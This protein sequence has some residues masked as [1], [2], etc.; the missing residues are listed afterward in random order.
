MVPQL[1]GRDHLATA[2]A[3]IELARTVAFAA[4][5]ALGGTLVGW[6]GAGTA[7]GLAAGLSALAA[8]LLGGL[9]DPSRPATAD[10]S[11]WRDA[12]EGLAFVARHS[13]LGPVFVTQFVFNTSYFI[14]LA[15]FVPYAARHLGLSAT[16]IGLTLGCSGAGMI[17]GALLAP[18]L[19]RRLPFGLLVG[20]GP[21]AGFVASIVMALTI[22][23]PIA[24]LAALSFFLIGAGPI[25]WVISTTTLRQV[26]TP[27]E[28]L[29]RVSAVNILSYAAR[30][31]GAGIG[32]LVGWRLG[33][34][35]CLIVAVA[36]FMFQTIV[37]WNSPAVAVDRQFEMMPFGGAGAASR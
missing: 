37:I 29:G 19:M 3:R 28:L 20:I 33:A 31:L 11:P 1:A 30:P 14:I 35:A 26:V 27:A 36:G 4:G 32:A 5:P 10:R 18:A 6:A 8:L 9:R 12:K 34:E 7:F 15:V 16:G 13:M 21:V 24:A 17:V 23:I 2:N 25:L 22:W